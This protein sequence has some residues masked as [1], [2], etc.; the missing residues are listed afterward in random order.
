MARCAHKT[1]LNRKNAEGPVWQTVIGAGGKKEVRKK[2][3]DGT[4]WPTFMPEKKW[5]R[6][7]LA[8]SLSVLF[9]HNAPA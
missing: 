7:V 1:L 4:L 8:Y 3:A 6:I 9:L 5:D 2:V